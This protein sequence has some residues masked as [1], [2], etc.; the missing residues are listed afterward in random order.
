MFGL[1]EKGYPICARHLGNSGKGVG[2]NRTNSGGNG[3]ECN[4]NT[5][6]SSFYLFDKLYF[7]ALLYTSRGERLGGGEWWDDERASERANGRPTFPF[8]ETMCGSIYNF[9]N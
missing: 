1:K 7:L 5:A 6:F 4:R 2:H 9:C 8:S 3:M